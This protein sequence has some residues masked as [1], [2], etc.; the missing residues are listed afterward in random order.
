MPWKF[1]C[2]MLFPCFLCCVVLPYRKTV[3]DDV[4]G[5]TPAKKVKTESLSKEEEEAMKKQNKIM[6]GY[7]DNLKAQ[8]KKKDLVRLLEYN[9]QG[10]P[11]GPEQVMDDLKLLNKNMFYQL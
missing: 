3:K 4:D 10:V 8:L 2:E 5:P 6:F 1:E 9:D 7:R 11:A